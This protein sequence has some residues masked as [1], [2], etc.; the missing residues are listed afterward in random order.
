[1]RDAHLHDAPEG[2]VPKGRRAYG[3]VPRNRGRNTTLIASMTL[4][5]AMGEAMVEEGATDRFVVEAY[6]EHILAPTLEEGRMVL[7]DNLP[8]H[9]TDVVRGLIEAR[10]ASLWLL[11]PYSPDLNPVE[12]EFFKVKALLKKVAVRTKEALVE[13]IAE[14]L[15][16]VRPR[17][18]ESWFAHCGY[19]LRDRPC[20]HR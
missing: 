1:M 6:V 8:A 19:E 11:S 3:R 13:A 9:K 14:A 20:E 2:R 5:G 10:G 4:E 12:E 17:D 15:S 18:A 16:A 7:L